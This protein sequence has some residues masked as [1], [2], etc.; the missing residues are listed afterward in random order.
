MLAI[1]IPYYKISFF[2]ETLQSLANQTNKNFKVYIGDD[3]SP[4]NPVE[5]LN[6]YKSS[7]NFTYKK[8]D[9]NL[10]ANSLTQ[11]WQR[12]IDLLG[13]EEWIMLLGDDDKLEKNVVDEFYKNINEVDVNQINIIRFAS[14]LVNSSTLKES[15][16]FLHK[17]KEKILDF[18]S[19]KLLDI[20]RSSLS[21][22]VFRKKVYKKYNFKN[23]PLAW[24]SD[25]MA[26]F[27]FSEG[28]DIFSI[29]EAK[30]FVRIFQESISGNP[31]N[32]FYKDTASI[33]FYNNLLLRKDVLKNQIVREVLLTRLEVLY[34]KRKIIVMKKWF[35]FFITRVQYLDLLNSVKLIRRMIIYYF[36]K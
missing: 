10:G 7:F 17:K 19:K 18:Y 1:V 11:Q 9:Q 27:E 26:W 16:V 36:N 32:F 21:E 23:Y 29:N 31:L 25:D 6:V 12:C 35:Y 33:E 5:L 8:F 3:A 14:V 13:N 34:K 20:T 30:V 28:K 4:N 24:H 22:Y 2:D 15:S